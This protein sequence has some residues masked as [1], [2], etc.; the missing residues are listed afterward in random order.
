MATAPTDVDVDY[1]FTI[2][3]ISDSSSSTKCTIKVDPDSLV[4][5]KA[6]K[7]VAW[8]VANFCDAARDLTLEFTYKESG[9]RKEI[10]KE[11]KWSRDKRVFEG[12]IKKKYFGNCKEFEEAPCGVYKYGI[13][14]GE[15]YLDP[16]IEII[17]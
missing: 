1:L 6:G 11:T 7:K 16:E 2:A 15:H 17:Y 10:L 13:R 5:M 9:A 14:V 12:K 8:T 3:V 4:K